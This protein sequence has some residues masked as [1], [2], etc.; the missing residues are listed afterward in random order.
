MKK[1]YRLH[2]KSFNNHKAKNYKE[3][4]SKM[5]AKGYQGM[6][7]ET[8][9]E[10]KSVDNNKFHAI[11]STEKEDRHGEIV[12]QDWDL[13]NFK[14][15]PVYLDSHNYS[16]IE[17]II[18]K[19]EKIKVKENKLEGD[20]VFALDNPRGELAY[21]LAEGGFLNTSSVGFIPKVFDDEGNILKS[22]LLEISGVVVPANAEALYE[23][24]KVKKEA[25]KEVEEVKEEV[26]EDVCIGNCSECQLE[27]CL[28]TAEEKIK[29][30]IK[31]EME[32]KEQAIDKILKAII[33][34]GEKTG[35]NSSQGDRAINTKINCAIRK[36]LKLKQ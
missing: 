3:L 17:Y 15:N 34:V 32:I 26:K 23:K 20:V 31:R 11:F 29:E 18:G 19:V 22:E 12:Y 10:F 21:K 36:L 6:L 25:K 30:A 9:T 4:W 5:K 28:K 27:N 14:K 1:F 35:R 13:K 33:L 16:S 8:H 2:S 24:K 7:I